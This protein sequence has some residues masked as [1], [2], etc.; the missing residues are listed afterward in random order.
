[1]P[2]KYRKSRRLN[3]SAEADDL[4]LSFGSV[5]LRPDEADQL[6]TL[7]RELKKAEKRAVEAEQRAA[8]LLKAS[9]PSM[10]SPG[11]PQSSTGVSPRIQIPRTKPTD[12]PPPCSDVISDTVKPVSFATVLVLMATMV[13]LLLVPVCSLG[14][15][16]WRSCSE[17]TGDFDDGKFNSRFTHT[18]IPIGETPGHPT[19][20]AIR[21]TRPKRAKNSPD[22]VRKEKNCDSPCVPDKDA[23]S[24]SS[25][26]S[27]SAELSNLTDEQNDQENDGSSDRAPMVANT[28]SSAGHH[29]SWVNG[30]T[31][32]EIAAMQRA[33]P[34][35]K[36]VLDWFWICCLHVSGVVCPLGVGVQHIWPKLIDGNCG[37]SEVEGPGYEKIPCQV[38]GYVPK[39][40]GVGQFQASKTVSSSEQRTMS[41]ASVFALAAAEEA[42]TQAKWTP[43]NEDDK[44]ESGVA[45]GMGMVGL[46]DIVNT[47]ITLQNKGYRKVSPYF[48]PRILTNMA[49][50]HISIRYNLKG[51]NHAV[52]TACTTGAHAIGD[53]FRFIRNGDANV[54]VAGGT[55]ACI[56]PIA[57][58]GF[59]RARALSKNFN[60]TP[61]SASR[62]F[63]K[64]RDGFVM[65]EGAAIVVLEE[66]QHAC[67]RGATILAE[68]LG[69]GLSGDAN[70]M[71]APRDDGEGAELCMRAALRDSGI[72]ADEVTYINAHATSTPLGDAAE[73]HA[74]KRLFRNQTNNL[75][76]SSTKGA[77]GHLLGAAGSLEAVFMVMAC[78]TLTH[79][80]L[81][82]MLHAPTTAPSLVT[83]A[84]EQIAAYQFQLAMSI[85][86]GNARHLSALMLY[87]SMIWATLL[88]HQGV[89]SGLI[90]QGVAV[91]GSQVAT[92]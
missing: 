12:V 52:S 10:P 70:H 27:Q 51:P 37:I 36:V 46:E 2:K 59:A 14:K 79:I 73:N 91:T 34:G 5:S 62:P 48:V 30:Y 81:S 17:F 74:I 20:A 45:V 76:V 72:A 53:A 42:L 65:S 87:L 26:G 49:A 86:K 18:A 40:D 60:A 69:Y 13:T 44:R 58:A 92:Y 67:N 15:L 54:M 38:A 71:T 7:K 24:G 64:D 88:V 82:L 90:H 8:S 50:G 31:S 66:Y 43:T 25:A 1:M 19:S 3:A 6:D 39:G 16:I 47:G 85:V 29:S 89:A 55:E 11:T 32:E 9:T 78:K 83:M 23:E 33:D 21:A 56:S 61:S 84:T 68:I 4:E 57:I 80:S 77:T 28:G 75:A 35:L 63:D 22:S 41:D